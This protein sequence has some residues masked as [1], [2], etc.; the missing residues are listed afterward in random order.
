MLY[1]SFYEYLLSLPPN[2]VFSI[3][4]Y[5]RMFTP[6]EQD[7]KYIDQSCFESVICED[8]YIKDVIVLPDG[9]LLLATFPFKGDMNNIAYYKLSEISLAILNHDTEEDE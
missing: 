2:T 7:A 3:W 6:H 8:V 4:Q 9:D 1:N 5:K